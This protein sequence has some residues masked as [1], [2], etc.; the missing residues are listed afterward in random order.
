MPEENLT[1]KEIVKNL[2]RFIIGQDKAK[3]AVAIALR[4]RYRRSQLSPEQREEITP[5]NILMI[6]PTGVGKTEIARRLASLSS[7]PFVK[8]EATKYTEVGYVGRDVE[9]M[10]R[11]LCDYAVRMVKAEKSAEIEK[12]VQVAVI[13]KLTDLLSG[14]RKTPPKGRTAIPLPSPSPEFRSYDAPPPPP[15]SSRENGEDSERTS[16]AQ[17]DSETDI[18][19]KLEEQ[20]ARI[21]NRT[22]G[23]L[24][25]GELEDELVEIDVEETSSA[26]I[27]V[28]SAHG[29]EEMGMQ[30][31]EMLGDMIPKKRKRRKLPVKEARDVLKAQETDRRLDMDAIVRIAIKRAEEHGIIFVDEIDKI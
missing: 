2:D 22:K 8:V 14:F 24:L 9:G 21:R 19:E 5:K 17:H 25:K 20:R 1:P 4:N 29:L 3:R 15:F 31:Q 30:L 16:D 18:E 27:E 26:S 6:G 7:A 23:K 11:D 13:E 10:V 12:E 28:L